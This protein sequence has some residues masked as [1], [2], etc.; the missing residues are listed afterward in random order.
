MKICKY[1]GMQNS[2]NVSF[3]TQCGASDFSHKCANCGT[4]FETP[5][6]PMC[7]TAADAVPRYCTNCGR[8][9]FSNCCPDCGTNLIGL[10]TARNIP[11]VTARP[12]PQV[13][14]PPVQQ[15]QSAPRK[16]SRI[17]RVFRFLTLVYMPYV[18]VWMFLEG[19]GTTRGSRIAAVVYALIITGMIAFAPREGYSIE[20]MYP[21]IVVCVAFYIAL[22]IYGVFKLIKRRRVQKRT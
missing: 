19:E 3:C 14:Y 22:I 10:P 11:T 6:C 7:G 5:Y 21:M 4:V 8:K 17:W 2:Q 18:G 12:V 1:C 15:V 16:P 20:N 13:S 9:T